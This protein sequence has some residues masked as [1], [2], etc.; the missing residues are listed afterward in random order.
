MM[1]RTADPREAAKRSLVALA[2]DGKYT[3]LE[4]AS[5]IEKSGFS[6]ADRRLYTNLVYGVAEKTLTLDYVAASLSSRPL[7]KLDAET[8]VCVR[9]GLY[10]LIYTDRIPDHAAVSETVSVAHAKSKGFVNAVLREF[11]RRGKRIEY[12]PEEDR[13][14]YLSVKYS[15]PEKMCRFILDKLGDEDGVKV[16]S[17]AGDRRASVRVNTLVTDAAS[18]I[19]DV[20]PD[21]EENTASPD[22][23]DVPSLSGADMT[24]KRWFVQDAASRLAVSAL[25]PEPGETVVDCCAAPGGKSFSAAIDM[26]NEGKIYSFDIH[27]NKINL[28]KRGAE[29][30]GITI[31]DAACRD[32]GDP[33]PDLQGRAD[34]VICDAPCSGLGVIAKKPDVKYKDPADFGRL[35]AVQ[36]RALLGAATYVKEGGVLVYSTCTVNPDENGGV[37]KRFLSE[38]PEFSLE[39]FEAGAFRSDGMLTLLPGE[40]N[41]DGFFICKMVKSPSE[42]DGKS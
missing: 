13:I 14:K 28:I 1:N 20:F 7:D 29:R 6:D 33:A 23:I 18:L 39:P 3:N 24:D 2:K 36:L 30:L 4:V 35:P 31:I 26:K 11:L 19:R 8:L 17:A 21:G 42:Q 41:T 32:A 12:P 10:Q 22:V 15:Y 25:A 5:R 38:H 37:V 9:L 40:R 27:E 34:R 16:L